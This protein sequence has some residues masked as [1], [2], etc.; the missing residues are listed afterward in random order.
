MAEHV[1][2]SGALDRGLTRL[3]RLDFALSL[4]RGVAVTLLCLVPVAWF[5]LGLDWLTPLP[6]A[7]RVGQLAL[8][9]A[10][11]VWLVRR[12]LVRGVAADRDA[13]AMALRAEKA[14]PDLEDRLI[15]AVQLARRRGERG[16]GSE[17]LKAAVER[18][19][20]EYAEQAALRVTGKARILRLHRTAVAAG[21]ALVLL[22]ASALA[23]M[24]IPDIASV[25]LR[26]LALLNA[27]YP[28]RTRIAKVTVRLIEDPTVELKTA[29]RTVLVPKGDAVTVEVDGRGIRP[30]QGTL[31]ARAGASGWHAVPLARRSD[32]EGGRA[33]PFAAAL[34]EVIE[35][36]DFYVRLGD[37]TSERYRMDLIDRPQ[38]VDIETELTQ[39]DYTG[40]EKVVTK[41]GY[42]RA[43]VGTAVGLRAK[44][45][46]ALSEATIRFR[47]TKGEPAAVPV[48]LAPDGVTL[49]AQFTVQ[50]DGAY[51][52]HLRDLDRLAN[53]APA[54]YQVRAVVDTLP[55]VL[56]AEPPADM[57]A[58]P[59]SLVT[60]DGQLSDDFGLRQAYLEYRTDEKAP[61]QRIAMPLPGMPAPTTMA[62]TPEGPR[63]GPRQA[64][65]RL[66][67][68]LVPLKLKAG[69]RLLCRVVARDWA[70]RPA[71]EVA[72]G[73]EVTIRVV[74]PEV[75]QKRLQ[76]D[77]VTAIRRVE[78]VFQV[79]RQSN[80]RLRY[81]IDRV[82]QEQER[83]QP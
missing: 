10:L 3:G 53:V 66:T 43:P 49:G 25:W 69:D 59:A 71:D 78:E 56:M 36:T 28:T 55:R 1:R 67:W 20:A 37:A 18:D 35:P 21:A 68:D 17:A 31:Y 38:V 50:T 58:T 62:A 77:L 61:Y 15:S 7:V 70:P 54:E 27:T 60:F 41:G 42:V 73:P 11:V 8:L 79:E 12:H 46:K 76:D 13:D 44:A 52:I 30:W 48:V 32:L 65:S 74:S 82:R 34:D 14:F 39:P 57:L 75:L 47:L 64:H 80:D 6:V 45:N 4:A 81:L 83:A 23:V 16:Y 51:T 5:L 2:H 26:R 40:L 9:A 24:R 63:P 19:A 72:R 29:G 33:R 22:L